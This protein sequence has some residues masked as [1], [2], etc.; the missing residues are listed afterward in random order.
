MP[1]RLSVRRMRQ[2]MAPRLAINTLLNMARHLVCSARSSRLGRESATGRPAGRWWISIRCPGEH[3]YRRG[4]VRVAG[5]VELRAVGDQY[6]YVH[7]RAHL[8]MPA[9]TGDAIGEGEAT[10]RGHR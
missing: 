7:G 5:V 2:A 3:A 6:Q 10:G 9:G 4:I 1:R 8:H